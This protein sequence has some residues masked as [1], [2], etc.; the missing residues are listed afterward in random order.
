MKTNLKKWLDNRI[1]RLGCYLFGHAEVTITE[2]PAVGRTLKNYRHH[3]KIIYACQPYWSKEIPVKTIC[4][5]CGR[6]AV[7]HI[8]RTVKRSQDD[9]A[10]D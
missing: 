2:Y 3:H 8:Y 1:A 4:V 6:G 10:S 5:S 7:N 9:F